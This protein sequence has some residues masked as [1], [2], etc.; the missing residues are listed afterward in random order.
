M[1]KKGFSENKS[2][3]TYEWIN[4][5]KILA[6]IAM[7][8]LNI[9][10]RFVNL[11]LTPKQEILFKKYIR[12][13]LFIFSMFWVGSRDIFIAILLTLIY[14]LFVRILFNDESAYCISKRHMDELYSMIDTNKDNVISEQEIKNAIEVLHHMKPKVVD[15]EKVGIIDKKEDDEKMPALYSY[16][17]VNPGLM[18]FRNM[19]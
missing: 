10:A 12:I 7:L 1:K 5:N 4:Q 17:N 6:G 15:N 3:S 16:M 8:F 13:E 9:G 19:I 18:G 14:L 11:N 2:L